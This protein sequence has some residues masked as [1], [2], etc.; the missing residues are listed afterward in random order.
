MFLQVIFRW[1]TTDD[2]DDDGRRRRRDGRRDGRRRTTTDDD[3]GTDD[4]TEDDDDDGTDDGQTTTGRRDGR[5]TTGHDGRT[6]KIPNIYQKVNRQ[7]TPKNRH[8][9]TFPDTLWPQNSGAHLLYIFVYTLP[10]NAARR[11][12][13]SARPSQ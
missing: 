1:T 5:R 4:G 6:E 12:S 9:Q 13:I 3:D 2:D 11:Y 8:A 7:F 10:T